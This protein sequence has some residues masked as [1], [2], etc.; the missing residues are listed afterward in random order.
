MTTP[1]PQPSSPFPSPHPATPQG[2]PYAT[3]A[4]QFGLAQPQVGGHQAPY[5]V[6]QQGT[7]YGIPQY[8]PQHGGSQPGYEACRFCGGVPAARVT[9]RAHQGFLILM[10]FRKY[11]G[12]MCGNCG[13]AVYR[14]MTTATLWQ[15]WWSPLSL[16]LFTPFTVIWNLV[17]RRKV[18]NLPL[19]VPGQR[20]TR[21]DP[22]KPVHQRPLAYIGLIPALWISVMIF[23]G[24]SQ[25]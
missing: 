1:P 25:S 17:A 24:L 18:S 6:P 2:N 20:G 12:P 21:A 23:H 5:G 3:P 10:R 15:G 7:P 9:F 19:P 11:D 13:T 4:G 16:F 8:A 14:T 22:G